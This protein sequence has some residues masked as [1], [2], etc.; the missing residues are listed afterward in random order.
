[1]AWLK[2]K[3]KIWHLKGILTIAP[4]IT[5]LVILG[6]FTGVYQTLEWATFDFWFRIRP[7]ESKDNRITVVNIEESDIQALGQ[8][9]ISD[10]KLAQ[11]L[12]NISQQQPRAIGL[13]LY[14]DLSYGSPQEQ[15]ALDQV[16]RSTPNLIGVEKVVGETVNAPSILKEQDQ[17]A[18]ADLVLDQDGKV[19]RG[20][21]AVAL[22]DG[23]TVLSLATK[24]A[25]MYLQQE[26][27]YLEALENSD[28]RFLGK[29]TFSPI[30]NNEGGYINVDSGGYQI[31]L[32]YRGNQDRFNHVS[33]TRVLNG[34]IPEDLFRDR[35]VLIGATADSLNDLFFTPYNDTDTGSNQ[36]PG[37]YVHANLTSHII[38]AALEGR[39]MIGGITE[40]G[41]WVW[42]L[43]WSFIGA[44]VSLLILERNLLRIDPIS[45]IELTLVGAF[46]PIGV[47]FS[48]SY[49]LFLWGWWLPTIAPLIAFILS[50]VAVVSYYNQNQKNL[51]FT[52]GLTSIANRRFFDTYV[53]EQWRRI[54]QGKDLSVILCDVDFFKFYND[55]YGH[56]AGDECLQKVAKAITDAIRSS[57][58]AARYGGEEFVI[59]L[60][61][62]DTETAMLVANRIRFKIKAMQ[63]PHKKSQVSDHVSISL[64]VASV[65]HNRPHSPEELIAF[66]DQGLYI[67]KEQG[68]DRAVVAPR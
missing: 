68:R 13:D 17:A 35:I 64:G 51:A 52:D 32:N 43:C 41:E 50:T 30:K 1:M 16:Y 58:M 54:K 59:V 61:N 23:Q 60:P 38:S 39:T 11:L 18:M 46:L 37:V 36:M 67:A 48:S 57:D 66:A 7:Q 10:G 34:D 14:R 29:A 62:T 3:Q 21:I 47:L 27:I 12:Q 25:L 28:R 55:T 44:S 5:L 31:I 22:D 9:P 53:E 49:Y 40:T 33:L 4:S 15:E 2:L 8:W 45:S 42:I 19:R 6:S 26:D 56:Q 65:N 63:I 20:L 24:L